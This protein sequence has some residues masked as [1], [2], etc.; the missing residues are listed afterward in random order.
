MTVVIAIFSPILEIT[1]IIAFLALIGLLLFAID[2]TFP[3][4]VSLLKSK[5]AWMEWDFVDETA[6]PYHGFS[7]HPNNYMKSVH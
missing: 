6:D 3:K 5:T 2:H 1:T 7:I 4:T